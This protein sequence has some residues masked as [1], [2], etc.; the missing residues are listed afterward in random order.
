MCENFRDRS[1]DLRELVQEPVSSDEEEVSDFDLGSGDSDSS[2]DFSSGSEDNYEPNSDDVRD[3][4]EEHTTHSEADDVGLP[5]GSSDTSSPPRPQDEPGPSCTAPNVVTTPMWLSIYPPEPEQ[6][7]TFLL[8]ESNTGP[9]NC[10]PRN[11]KPIDYFF[12]FFTQ[13]I[14][15]MITRETNIYADAKIRKGRNEGRVK[16]WSRLNQWVDITVSELKK[17]IAVMINMGLAF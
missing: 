2:T 6:Q 14:W 8:R 13:T 15:R 4:R 7:A 9:Q 1:S 17:Y 3:W 16:R 12:L 11:S 5:H 10:P